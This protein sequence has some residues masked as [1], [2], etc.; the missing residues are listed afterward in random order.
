MIKDL[1][2]PDGVTYTFGYITGADFYNGSTPLIR[3][4]YN[5]Q[6]YVADIKWDLSNTTDVAN[7][8][9]SSSIRYISNLKLPTSLTNLSSLFYNSQIVLYPDM[10]TS[11]VTN[12]SQIF[13]MYS[14]I[15]PLL[16]CNKVTNF[17]NPWGYGSTNVRVIKGFKNLKCSITSYFLDKATYITVES[18]MNVI[19]NLYDWSQGP[20][21][22]KYVW[23]DGSSYNYGTT[24]TLKFGTTNLDKLTDEQKAVAIN[25]GWTLT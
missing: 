17:S 9:A 25:K 5:A 16:D 3:P 4:F 8:F 10:D 13:G 21:D 1:N 23:E 14:T 22:G 18:L 7:F 24:H 20:A 11:N 15:Y 6:N 2:F 12:M 19:N